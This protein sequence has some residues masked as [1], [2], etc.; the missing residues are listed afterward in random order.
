MTDYSAMP[1]IE[2]NRN[3]VDEVVARVPAVKMKRPEEF[4]DLRF[5]ED[6]ETEGF[7]KQFQKRI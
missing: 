5:L 3:A 2:G 7:F 4:I 6:R 1:N